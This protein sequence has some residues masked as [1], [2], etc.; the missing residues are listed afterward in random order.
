MWRVVNDRW[1]KMTPRQALRDVQSHSLCQQLWQ[2]RYYVTVTHVGKMN[3]LIVKLVLN[4]EGIRCHR[5]AFIVLSLIATEDYSDTVII[6]IIFD[7]LTVSTRF[8]AIHCAH[9]HIMQQQHK[10]FPFSVLWHKDS[11]VSFAG[12]L[13]SWK[14]RFVWEKRGCHV[15]CFNSARIWWLGQVSHSLI[16]QHASGSRL[17]SWSEMN[18][19]REVIKVFLPGMH[20]GSMTYF[21]EL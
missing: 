8:T 9:N 7:E 6:T 3:G 19:Y 10:R 15:D 20:L 18:K 17:R 21:L 1:W 13:R 12:K 5:S 14:R 2:P 4:K 16:L 11:T